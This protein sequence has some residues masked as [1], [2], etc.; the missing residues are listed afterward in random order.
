MTPLKNIQK[1]DGFQE[2]FRMIRLK[3]IQKSV[4][5][6]GGLSGNQWFSR[7]ATMISLERIKKLMVF[8]MD[9]GDNRWFSRKFQLIILKNIQKSS[10]FLKNI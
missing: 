6:K 8:K 10:D 1:I 9:S 3:H 5:F 4:V 2:G 7:D